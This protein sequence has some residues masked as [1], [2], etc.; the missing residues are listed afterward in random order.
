MESV[1]QTGENYAEMKNIIENKFDDVHTY[2]SNVKNVQ[3]VTDP[4]E[5]HPELNQLWS[6]WHNMEVLSRRVEIDRTSFI[7]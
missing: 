2:M 5:M 7:Q 6:A 1:A 3:S 4:L